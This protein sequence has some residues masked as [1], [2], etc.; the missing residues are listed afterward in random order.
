MIEDQGRD[1]AGMGI[2]I[3]DE[4]PAPDGLVDSGLEHPEVLGG[5][6]EG[7]D[8]LGGDA[9]AVVLLSDAQQIGVSDVRTRTDGYH[10]LALFLAG[11]VASL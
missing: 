4:A 5:P 6:A 3:T 8:G 2:G 10:V 11:C 9:G 7:Q 1:I